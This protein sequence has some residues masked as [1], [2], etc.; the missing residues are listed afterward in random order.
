MQEIGTVCAQ[1]LE[2]QTRHTQLQQQCTAT[3]LLDE[4]GLPGVSV[5]V[6]LMPTCVVLYTVEYSR[7]TLVEIKHSMQ[8]SI[9]VSLMSSQLEH[10]RNTFYSLVSRQQHVFVAHV[11]L[12][13]KHTLCP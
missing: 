11:P 7:V 12:D 8:S 3:V 10:T 9:N 1:A 4:G 6:C 2:R 5:V 13:V